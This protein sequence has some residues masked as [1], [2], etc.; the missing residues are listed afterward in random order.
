MSESR[1]NVLRCLS[2]FCLLRSMSQ[3]FRLAGK[4]WQKSWRPHEPRTWLLNLFNSILLCLRAFSPCQA[5]KW[6]CWETKRCQRGWIDTYVLLAM[7]TLLLCLLV[8]ADGW[9]II[10]TIV[11]MAEMFVVTLAVR[12][13]DPLVEGE[14]NVSSP[15]RSILLLL[16]GYAELIVGF[17]VLYLAYGGVGNSVYVTTAGELTVREVTLSGPAEALYFSFV[18][19]TTLGY[20]DFAPSDCLSRLLVGIEVGAGIILIGLMLAS[21]VGLRRRPT[22]SD[23]DGEPN[24]DKEIES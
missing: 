3:D 12:F 18:T 16:I 10:V 24:E 20:G 2:R 1:S 19:I 13:V 17:A 5:V 21:F 22:C 15:S 14:D 8:Q 23:A 7:A 11:L 9:G 4:M 6:A